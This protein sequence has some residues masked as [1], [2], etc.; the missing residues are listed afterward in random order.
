[1]AIDVEELRR[2]LRDF[3]SRSA[4]MQRAVDAGDEAID[5]AIRLLSDRSEAT[6]WSAMRILA[7]VG[8][9]RAVG[10]LIEVME[11]GEN[12]I[13]AINALWRITGEDFG[14]DA[15]AWRQWAS[16]RP[17]SDAPAERRELSDEELVEAA[18]RD[19]DTEV[20]HTGD[21]YIVTVALKGGRSQRVC[22]D[23]AAKDSQGDPLVRLYTPCGKAV[24]EK[25]EWALKNNMN[26]PYGAIGIAR[27]QGVPCFVMIDAHLRATANPTD[28]GKS[29][30]TLAANGDVVEKIL[31]RQDKY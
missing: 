15:A 25:Y 29:I 7:E 2:D 22:V 27:M 16:A 4:A 14:E 30:M 9:A 12:A 19:L 17:G 13:E 28:L 5:P 26:L 31:T 3:R 11:R 20:S 6:R 23:F 10:P 18:T 24:Q 21:R 8:G 1:M